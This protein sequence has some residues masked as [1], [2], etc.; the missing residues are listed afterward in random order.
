M[1]LKVRAHQGKHTANCGD[2]IAFAC[3]FTLQDHLIKALNNFM[4]GSPFRNVTILPSLVAMG[5]MFMEI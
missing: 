1:T 2:V 4:V 3:H 5:T